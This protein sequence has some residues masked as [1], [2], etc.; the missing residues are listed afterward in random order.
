[1]RNVA[2]KMTESKTMMM[3]R[4]KTKMKR[5]KTRKSKKALCYVSY[6]D[7]IHDYLNHCD[8]ESHAVDGDYDADVCGHS[9]HHCLVCDGIDVGLNQYD[10][11][12]NY[13]MVHLDSFETDV[14]E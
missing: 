11:T 2:V 14:Y 7:R 6:G 1:M 3:M 9:H 4:M 13:D 12:E 10:D 8:V 5:M